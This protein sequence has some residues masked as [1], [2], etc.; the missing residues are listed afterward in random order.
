MKLARNR[1]TEVAALALLGLWWGVPAIRIWQADRMVD[2]LCA[3][4]GGF[5]IHE[6]V[7]LSD[8]EPEQAVP[9]AALDASVMQ[10]TDKYYRTRKTRY[11]SGDSN[12]PE[13]LAIIQDRYRLYR[14]SDRKLLGEAIAYM[15]TGGDPVG[16]WR[17]SPHS[18]PQHA[19]QGLAKRIFRKS[20]A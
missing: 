1:W 6:Q 8:D 17:S 18:C 4:D 10:V 20:G 15:R 16:P 13:S 14:S 9:S 11:I 7:Q 5:T 2:E 19:D 12:S 3:K